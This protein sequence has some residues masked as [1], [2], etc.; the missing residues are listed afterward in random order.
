MNDGTSDS[1]REVQLAFS[2]RDT[3]GFEK[4]KLGFKEFS[5]VMVE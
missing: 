4:T 5:A 3:G 2:P 1:S